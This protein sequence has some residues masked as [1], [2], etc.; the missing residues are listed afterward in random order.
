MLYEL[1]EDIQCLALVA[2]SKQIVSE[3]VF[4]SDLEEL[5]LSVE[6][7]RLTRVVGA[8]VDNIATDADLHVGEVWVAHG[9]L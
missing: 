4:A 7:I 3:Q 8:E 2:E 5:R 6:R 1:V 9:D